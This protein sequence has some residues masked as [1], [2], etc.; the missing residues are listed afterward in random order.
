MTEPAVIRRSALH[1]AHVA[2]GARM[3]ERD[4]WQCPEGYAGIEDEL[5]T[6]RSD[7][8]LADVSPTAKLDV[9]GN[10]ALS[11]IARRLSLPAP[12]TRTVMPLSPSVSTRE[13]GLHPNGLLC[14]LTPLHTRLFVPP[15]VAAR[16]ATRW[17]R[18]H[19][20]D[21]RPVRARLTDVTSA[22]T[23]MQVSGP[24]SRELL[25]KLT[26]LDLGAETFPH[27]TCAQTGIADVHA[28]ILRTDVRA[29][30]SFQ[31]CCGREFGAFV[32]DTL[33]D[34]GREFGVRP[35]GRAALRTLAAEG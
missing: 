14:C 33:L 35:V 28:L 1:A 25:R 30:L 15:D 3:G 11:A 20:A 31:I 13:N 27:L 4:G 7:A 17:A 29:L 10:D 23:V 9:R 5:H 12:V 19:A 32:W 6:V 18:A 22:Y 26:A 34:A 16:I 24:R 2:A 8:G 21:T